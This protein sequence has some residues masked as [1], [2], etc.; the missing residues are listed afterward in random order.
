M[1][2]AE[3][4]FARGDLPGCLVQLQSDVRKQP[5]AGNLRVFLAQ[6]LMV[7]GDW[8][9]ALNQLGVAAELDAAALPMMHAY[10]AAIQC[11]RLRA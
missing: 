2:S 10:R 9:R 11:E 6:T 8:D 3:E 4:L 1:S 5:A 7:C